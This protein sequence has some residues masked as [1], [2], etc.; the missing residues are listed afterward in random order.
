MEREQLETNLK[1]LACLTF[2]GILIFARL[3]FFQN[4]KIQI[5]SI[6]SGLLA[7]TG[8]LFGARTFIIFKLYEI[9]Y[10]SE[11]Y[12][13]WHKESSIIATNS[14]PLFTP[15]KRLD[16]NLKR[17][18]SICKYSLILLGVYCFLPSPEDYVTIAT[19]LN[20]SFFEMFNSGN[21]AGFFGLEGSVKLT[22]IKVFSDLV[23]VY[24][25]YNVL[26]VFLT[27]KSINQNIKAIIEFWETRY[28]KKQAA[29]TAKE[30][31]S[32]ETTK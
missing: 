27:I 10:S 32:Q 25:F 9:V 8:F 5:S 21:I 15:L 12:Q 1:R 7:L 30:K 2:A 19:F 4:F 14:E 16:D 26:F 18:I 28:E 31:S 22:F 29:H 3:D 17:A 24:F 23:L 13:D 20:K 6:F 11:E